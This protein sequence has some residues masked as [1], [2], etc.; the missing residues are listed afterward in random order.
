MRET[1]MVRQ[2]FD[3]PFQIPHDIHI[4]KLR[5]QRSHQRGVSGGAIES[6]A[7]DAGA[8]EEVSKRFHW[9]LAVVVLLGGIRTGD[10][11]KRLVILSACSWREGPCVPRYW[12]S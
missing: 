12:L 7:S 11:L 4:G 5:R 10:R 2:R 8:G 3:R 9:R 1:A 6:R